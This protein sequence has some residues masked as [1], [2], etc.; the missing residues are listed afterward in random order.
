MLAG[1]AAAPGDETDNAPPSGS[2]DKLLE[3][4]RAM[5]EDSDAR[6]IDVANMLRRHPD[7]TH[8]LADIDAVLKATGDYDF[9]KALAL[10]GKG[11]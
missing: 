9:D 3:E 2:A 11:G 7:G 5:L 4:L 8:R 6:A 10:L 1:L